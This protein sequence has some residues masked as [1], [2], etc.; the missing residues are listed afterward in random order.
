MNIK[1]IEENYLGTSLTIVTK[2]GNK[3]QGEILRTD[4][5]SDFLRLKTENGITIVSTSSIESIY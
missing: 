5:D 2:S 3:I 4:E 1:S